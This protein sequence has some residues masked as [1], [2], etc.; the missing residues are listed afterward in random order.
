MLNLF[1]GLSDCVDKGSVSDISSIDARFPFRV[2]VY[3]G[4]G[5]ADGWG[6]RVGVDTWSIVPRGLD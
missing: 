4:F 1:S 6:G 3:I 2:Q 5:P